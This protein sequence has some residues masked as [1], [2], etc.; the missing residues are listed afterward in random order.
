VWS[1]SPSIG[2]ADVKRAQ[3]L[4]KMSETCR[5]KDNDSLSEAQ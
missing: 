5:E 4:A 3:L 1:L 2:E